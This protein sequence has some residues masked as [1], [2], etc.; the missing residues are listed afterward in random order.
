MAMQ[1]RRCFVQRHARIAVSAVT[2]P[3]TI[4]A[5]QGVGETA[6]VEKYQHLMAPAQRRFDFVQ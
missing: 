5:E 1:S 2:A 6:A 4:V 3:A